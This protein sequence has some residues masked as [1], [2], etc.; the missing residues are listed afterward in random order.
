MQHPFSRVIIEVVIGI[1]IKK[2][3][4]FLPALLLFKHFVLYP[5]SRIVI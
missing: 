5:L 4:V 3:Q 1:F 2:G